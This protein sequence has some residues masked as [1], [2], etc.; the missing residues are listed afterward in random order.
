ML[1]NKME[2]KNHVRK[3]ITCNTLFYVLNQINNDIFKTSLSV[4]VYITWY[5]EITNL[6]HIKLLVNLYLIGV[7]N[8]ILDFSGSGYDFTLQGG[9]A[10][11][12]ENA[13]FYI[14]LG[15]YSEF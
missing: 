13:T 6:L 8:P 3:E 9:G 5:Q 4:Y 1:F 10:F 11:Y 7:V 12:A 2:P 15:C 14:V